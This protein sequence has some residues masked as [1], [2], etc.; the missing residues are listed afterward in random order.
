MSAQMVKMRTTPS[1]HL[2]QPSLRG[3]NEILHIPGTIFTGHA[4]LLGSL[5]HL[6]GVALMNGLV[7]V[8]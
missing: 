3:L 7:E 5:R 4:D 1:F 8:R 2:S 6:G